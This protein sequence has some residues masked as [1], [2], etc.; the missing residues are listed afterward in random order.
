MSAPK[1][2]QGHHLLFT[3]VTNTSSAS[4]GGC[5]HT[6]AL[7][8]K[9]LKKQRDRERYLRNKEEI[10]RRKRERYHEKKAKSKQQKTQPDQ[11]G[12]TGKENIKPNETNGWL[13]RN[14]ASLRAGGVDKKN[15]MDMDDSITV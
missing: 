3:D 10:L 9:E 7:S 8:S 4:V 2:S 1:G 14:D 5:S 13:Q 6:P 12:T 11:S 15:M